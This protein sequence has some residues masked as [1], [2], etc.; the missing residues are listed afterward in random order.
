MTR[1][2]AVHATAPDDVVEALGLRVGEPYIFEVVAGQSAVCM[3]AGGRSAPTDLSYYHVV[4]P[5]AA[6]RFSFMPSGP[7]WVWAGQPSRL[8]VTSRRG[9]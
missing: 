3:F 9:R 2:Y 1:K 6:G 8:V 4:E 5:G 7:L